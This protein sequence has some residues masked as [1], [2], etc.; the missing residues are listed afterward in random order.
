MDSQYRVLGNQ[1]Q[2]NV[3]KEKDNLASERLMLQAVEVVKAAMKDNPNAFLHNMAAGSR[4]N[5]RLAG[6]PKVFNY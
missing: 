4:R 5:G 1:V 3:N 6:T 2:G